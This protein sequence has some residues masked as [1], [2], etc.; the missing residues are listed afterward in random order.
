MNDDIAIVLAEALKHH[1]KLCKLNIIIISNNKI[2]S[3]GA[4]A[5]ANA[6]H[7]CTHLEELIVSHNNFKE[8]GACSIAKSLCHYA[9]CL[10]ISLI[11][12]TIKLA[13]KVL[14]PLL[15]L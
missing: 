6:I 3:D 15:M 13:M 11:L 12:A 14:M 4:N 2:G 10:L 7:H 5:I 1:K 8:I 9:Q